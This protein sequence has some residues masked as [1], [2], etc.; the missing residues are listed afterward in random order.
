[1]M[2]NWKNMSSCYFKKMLVQKWNWSIFLRQF[3]KDFSSSTELFPLF[4]F[5]SFLSLFYK[6]RIDLSCKE[7]FVWNWQERKKKKTFTLHVNFLARSFPQIRFQRNHKRQVQQ[8]TLILLISLLSAVCT[9][10]FMTSGYKSLDT[11]S[12]FHF[13]NNFAVHLIF[14]DIFETVSL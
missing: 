5:C 4:P 12:N 7:W 14:S 2:R 13:F 11:R 8:F 6:T 9:Y 3:V 1:M 10:L